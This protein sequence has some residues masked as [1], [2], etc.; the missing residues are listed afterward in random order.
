MQKINSLCRLYNTLYACLLQ[1]C[2]ISVMASRITATLTGCATACSD[3]QQRKP[4]GSTL[5]AL[6]DGNSPVTGKL[7]L[8]IIGNIY[9]QYTTHSSHACTPK[10]TLLSMWS[11]GVSLVSSL[12]N[13]TPTIV[14]ATMYPL[15]VVIDHHADFNTVAMCPMRFLHSLHTSFLE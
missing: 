7:F 5:V 6:C 11:F 13:L 3:W 2:Y 12:C 14:I 9:L 10:I 15:Y 4:Q 8:L 1:W